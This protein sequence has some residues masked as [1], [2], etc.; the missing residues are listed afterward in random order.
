MTTVKLFPRITKQMALAIAQPIFDVKASE[1]K[2]HAARPQ[3]CFAPYGV[4]T[5]VPCWWVIGSWGGKDSEYFLRSSRIMVI[6]RV[7]GEILFDG[8]ANDEG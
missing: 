3:N 7:T 6:S 5:D 1:L 4:P 8:D 2:F